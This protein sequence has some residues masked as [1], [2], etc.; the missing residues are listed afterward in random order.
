ML[1]FCSDKESRRCVLPAVLA[2]FRS[3][4][5]QAMLDE[6]LRI[7]VAAAIASGLVTPAH[8]VIETFPSEQGS[9]RVTD[10]TTLYK[11]KKKSSVPTWFRVVS[12]RGICHV[13][14][15]GDGS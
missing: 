12:L 15:P 10:A 9:Q 6:L 13:A 4:I 3:C 11:A 14:P 2:T 7:Q 5:D 1:P 8:L